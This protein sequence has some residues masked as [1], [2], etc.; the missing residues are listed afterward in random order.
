MLLPIT[1]EQLDQHPPPPADHSPEASAGTSG[2]EANTE[3]DEHTSAQRESQ[4]PGSSSTPP[5]PP[6]GGFVSTPTHPTPNRRLADEKISFSIFGMLQTVLNSLCTYLTIKQGVI[7]DNLGTITETARSTGTDVL[8]KTIETT[9]QQDK[10]KY[11]SLDFSIVPSSLFATFITM[12]QAVPRLPA[13]DSPILPPIAL[14]HTA[15]L[16]P[17]NQVQ[18]WGCNCYCNSQFDCKLHKSLPL[19]NLIRNKVWIANQLALSSDTNPAV[20]TPSIPPQSQSSA[21]TSSTSTSS[22]SIDILPP[23]PPLT[24]DKQIT[25]FSNRIRSFSLVPTGFWRAERWPLALT[26]PSA[27][28][29]SLASVIEYD[30]RLIQQL[31]SELLHVIKEEF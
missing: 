20:S 7:V 16:L 21:S 17:T 1:P 15:I 9:W 25:I 14:P 3:A 6:Q 4:Q 19:C 18:L 24:L 28:T 10:L 30:V 27:N 22:P 12:A 23:P 11:I 13:G 2:S 5:P 26:N 29:T 8:S 31:S